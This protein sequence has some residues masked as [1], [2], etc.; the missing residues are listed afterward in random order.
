MSAAE[1]SGQSLLVAFSAYRLVYVL[2][3][4]KHSAQAVDLAMTAVTGLERV[5]ASPTMEQLSVYGGLHLAAAN[6]AAARYDTPTATALLQSAQEI[7]EKLG[8][9]ANFMGTAFG[10]VNVAIHV[11]SVSTRLG[12][13]RTA[14]RTGESLDPT[15]MPTGLIGRRTQVSLDLAC[16]Y[17][18][19]RQDA[20]SVNALLA[21]ELLSPQLV[22]FDSRTRD[23]ITRLLQREHRA[24]TP[25]LRPLAHRAGVI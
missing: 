15:V 24:S 6:A 21:A 10:P 19:R 16:A 13:A 25:Q 8:R 4:K 22:R 17:A 9:D 14:I 12:D 7:A 18:M 5:M 2:A 3:G 1:Q 11:M 23:V 20:A